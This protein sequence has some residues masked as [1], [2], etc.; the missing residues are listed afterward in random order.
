MSVDLGAA[1]GAAVALPGGD[2]RQIA[3]RLTTKDGAYSIPPT[4]FL[5]PANWRRFH[6]SEL[7][8]KV[9]ETRRCTEQTFSY[10]HVHQS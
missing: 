1:D 8:N 7:I 10:R 6:L 5:V 4:K 9:L 3:V 2:E